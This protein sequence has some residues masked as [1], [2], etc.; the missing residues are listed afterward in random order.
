MIAEYEETFVTK[1]P[2]ALRKYSRKLLSKRMCVPVLN[3]GF[4][5]CSAPTINSIAEVKL[6]PHVEKISQFRVVD[7]VEEWRVGNNKIDAAVWNIRLS[8][9]ATGQV[10]CT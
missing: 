9:A 1:D 3:L 5:P 10:D 2:V 7:V 8:G 6:L 4:S